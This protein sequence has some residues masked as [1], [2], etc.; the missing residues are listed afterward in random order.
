MK[1]VIKIG[2][3]CLLL[4]LQ[5][6]EV[7]NKVLKSSSKTKQS[8]EVDVSKEIDT[9]IED[10]SVTTIKEKADSIIKTP[11]KKIE[12]DTKINNLEDIRDLILLSDDLV[13]V[14]QTY[15]TLS[16]NL[17]T[18]AIVKP[19]EIKFNLDRTTTKINDIKTSTSLKQDST[20]KS[21]TKIKEATKQKE[22]KNVF[23]VVVL[24][25]GG[26][27]VLYFVSKRFL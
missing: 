9:E 12:S 3:L 5:S 17:K 2:L 27:A 1:N 18:T 23:W 14:K 13:E 21:D 16:K 10:R 8:T 24:G 7:F 11:E 22:P 15:D 6:C 19:R 26:L 25:L 4:T 20:A